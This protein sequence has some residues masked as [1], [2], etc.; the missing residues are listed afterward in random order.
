MSKIIIIT[1]IG[2]SLALSNVH[3]FS[4]GNWGDLLK[5]GKQETE[6]KANQPSTSLSQGEIGQG[7]K[8][9]LATGISTV[10]KQLG[11]QGGFSQD[12]LISIPMPEK[13]RTVEKGL[14]AAGQDKIADEFISTM[15]SA[16]EKAVPI[17][18]DIFSDAIRN[19]SLDDARK[20]LDG[21]EHAATDYFKNQNNDTLY[22]AILPIV[23]QATANAGV[24]RAY[25]QL[26][27]NLGGFL[28]GFIKTD[29]LDVDDY[30][31]RKALDGM[32]LKLAAEEKKIRQNPLAQSSQLL[33]KVF[34]CCKNMGL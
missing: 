8:E 7:L 6:T 30:V 16:A 22:T 17:T 23:K 25:K 29:S 9:A 32:F 31:T 15:N 11:S 10:I 13:L 1:T 33:K 34:S 26:T 2:L 24:T 27:A 3:A 5:G 4:L 18:A 14:R 20:I 28:G 19:M 12:A 21:S